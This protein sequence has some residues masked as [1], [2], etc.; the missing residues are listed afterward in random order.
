MKKL[1]AVILIMLSFSL[2]AGCS[3]KDQE[4]VNKMYQGSP[5]EFTDKQNTIMPSFDQTAL[6]EKGEQ[7]V[8]METNM[9]TVKIRLFPE[10]A[11]K[12]V[13][14]FIGLADKGY[15]DGIIFHRVI[16][17]F[18]IQGGDPTGTGR[19]GESLWGGKFEDEFNSNLTNMRGA[20]S[21]ANAGPGTNGSQFFIVQN[22][23]G[24]SRLDNKHTVFGQVFE[25]M[26]V[27]DEIANVSRDASDKPVK[28][29]VMEKVSV[30]TY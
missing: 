16:P 4:D 19:G 21:M 17:D 12:T 8:V 6:P 13:E 7:I 22:V 2:L 24:E 29:V 9:G 27:V 23:N 14:N 25:G 28:D 26:D 20:I 3:L 18:M 1:L 5:E 11:P 15:Y 30:E 10:L